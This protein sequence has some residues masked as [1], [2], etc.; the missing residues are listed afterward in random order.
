MKKSILSLVAAVSISALLTACGGSSSNTKA[1]PEKPIKV[2]PKDTIIG[3]KWGKAFDLENKEY[4]LTIDDSYSTKA[5]IKVSLTR[6]ANTPEVDLA[7]MAGSHETTNKY[8]ADLEVEFFDENGESLFTATTY[9]Y[10]EVD[11]LLSLCE[12]DQ[13]TVTFNAYEE[14]SVIR[15]ARTF[16]ITSTMETNSSYGGGNNDIADAD[17]IDQQIEEMNDAVG[18]A[19]NMMNAVGAAMGAAADAANAARQLR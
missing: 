8:V 16:R 6:N 4:T 10:S 3:G 7:Q 19:T 2:T 13:A 18:A 5:V 15:K 11:K 9:G 1:E 12:G 17:D 14:R